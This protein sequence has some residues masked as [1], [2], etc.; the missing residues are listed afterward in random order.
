MMQHTKYLSSIDFR[1]CLNPKH[2]SLNIMNGLFHQDSA[3]ILGKISKNILTKTADS[4][5]HYQTAKICRQILVCIG[6]MERFSRHQQGKLKVHFQFYFELLR[7][8]NS[9]DWNQKK[10]VF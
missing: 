8:K 9:M 1:G 7:F 10:H 3:S 5:D 4:A 6:H 2:P